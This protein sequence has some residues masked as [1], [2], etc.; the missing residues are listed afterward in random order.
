MGTV[1]PGNSPPGVFRAILQGAVAA[2]LL[3][4]PDSPPG[5]VLQ[6]VNRVVFEHLRCRLDADHDVALL[7]LHY[8]RRGRLAFAGAHQ[9]IIVFRQADEQWTQLPATGPRVGATRDLDP[10]S[11][12]ICSLEDGDLL[13]LCT[14]GA[15][16]VRNTAGQLLGIETLCGELRRTR[17]E[18]VNHIRDHLL[19]LVSNWSAETGDDF[20]ILVGR[21]GTDEE[22]LSLDE[23]TS[24]GR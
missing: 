18:P 2:C 24:P 16:G 12:T 21:Y 7:L 9:D 3:T 11:D 10:V 8:D 20:T 6:A 17:F 19:S 13:L 15:V 1:A 22:T 14:E 5:V 4:T 23:I